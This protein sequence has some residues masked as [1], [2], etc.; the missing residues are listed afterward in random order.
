ML[1]RCSFSVGRRIRETAPF[2]AQ[3]LFVWSGLAGDLSMSTL[4]TVFLLHCHSHYSLKISCRFGESLEGQVKGMGSRYST[5][6][7]GQSS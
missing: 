4:P 7:S 2:E 3:A 5:E 1:R 6:K